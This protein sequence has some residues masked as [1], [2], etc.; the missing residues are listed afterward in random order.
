M[1]LKCIIVDDEYLA[2]RILN[3]YIADIPS[4]DL[5][6]QFTSAPA[7]LDFLEK[8]KADLVLLDIQMPGLNGIDFIKNLSYKPLVIFTTAR[9]E[10]AAA[11]YDLDVLDY[12]VKPISPERFKKAIEKA[13]QYQQLQRSSNEE[14]AASSFLIIKADYRTVQVAYKEIIFIEGLSEYVRIHTPEKKY[15]TLA[16]LK[17]IDQQLP[18]GAFIRI[19]KSYLVGKK[20]IESYNASA[21]TLRN[22]ILLPVGRKYKEAFLHCMQS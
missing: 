6:A 17:E 12:L 21:V 16:A 18:A 13:L 10:Y 19:H 2:L 4:L 9:Q 8:N 5:L 15:I 1:K 11:A 20:F 7:A 22:Q 3:Q 14:K